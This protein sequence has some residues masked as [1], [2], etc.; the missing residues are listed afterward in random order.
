MIEFVP[1]DESHI[2][3]MQ[4]WLADGEAG[5][6]YG[7]NQHKTEIELR[8]K[9]LIEKPQRNTRCF[10]IQHQGKPIGYLQ[11]Y[12]LSD[13]PQWSALVSGVPH[14]YGMDLFIGRDDL[15]GQ[16]I[17]TRVVKTALA[18]LVFSNADAKRCVIG[19]DPENR[20]AIRCYEKCGFNHTRTV[21]TTA[22]GEREYI[23]ITERPNNERV[24]RASAR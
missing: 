20:R 19:P 17:G 3:L 1:L 7:R 23:M 11:Y 8:Q 15:I 2:S 12:R 10:I 13:D 5:R 24:S 6:W 16:S 22:T 18:D 4:R 9:Y 21:T 14:D